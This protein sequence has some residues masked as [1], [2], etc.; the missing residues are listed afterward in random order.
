[1]R[2]HAHQMNITLF[3]T[4]HWAPVAGI[5][6]TL[7]VIGK[8]TVQPTISEAYFTHPWT[9]DRNMPCN[10]KILMGN[11]HTSKPYLNHELH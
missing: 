9:A 8:V 11:R 2:L 6:L 1:M 10:T 5:Y 4:F 7:T 3:T